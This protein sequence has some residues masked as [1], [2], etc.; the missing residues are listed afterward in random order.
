MARTSRL[1]G[2]LPGE[3]RE[4][5]ATLGANLRL[6][7]KRRGMSVAALAERLMVSPPTVRKLELGEPTVSLGVVVAALWALGLGHELKALA[8]P[9]TDQLGLRAEMRRLAGG[10]G[11]KATADDLDF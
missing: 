10:K 11:R 8:A 4:L 3:A 6:A 9:E 2:G 5:L 7:R 1:T